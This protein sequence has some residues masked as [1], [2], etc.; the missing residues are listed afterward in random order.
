MNQSNM[1][2]DSNAEIRVLLIDDQ[3]IVYDA[4][5]G[6]LADQPDIQLHYCNDPSK[7]LQVAE[8]IHPTVILQD[9]IMPDVDGL[10]L[11]NYFRANHTTKDIPLIVLS[12]KEDPIVKA[13]GFRAGANDYMVKLPDRIELIARIRYHSNAY[14]VLCERNHAYQCLEESQQALNNQLAEAAAYVKSAIPPPL[15]TGFIHADWC[16]LPSEQLGGD[17]L[18]YQW[19]DSDH[20]VFFLL[21]VCGHGVG[22]ALLSISIL[23]MLRSQTLTHAEIIDPVKVL[24]IL[25]ANFPMEKHQDMFFTIWYG[26]YHRPTREISFSSGGHPPAIVLT[27]D[28]HGEKIIDHLKVDGSVVGAAT[29]ANFISGAYVVAKGARLY[30]FSDGIYEIQKSDDSIQTLREFL[31]VYKAPSLEGKS[32]IESILDF[33]RKVQKD[34][35]FKDDVSILELTFL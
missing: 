16:F 19:V 7:A 31:E 12:S 32:T 33:S 28:E 18:G 35:T 27:N 4:I 23:N 3:K 14:I 20:F 26:V 22:A 5:K 21:D 1:E 15:K 9:L 30:L 24:S 2:K 13:D 25:N 29:N 34:H 8:Q 6:M 10:M 17:A 11:V